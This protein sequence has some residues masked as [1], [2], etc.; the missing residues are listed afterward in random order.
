M[1]RVT[2]TPTTPPSDLPQLLT[3]KQAAAY[4]QQS[5]WTIREA[6]KRGE[7][8]KKC[9]GRKIILIPREHFTQPAAEAVL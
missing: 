7:I 1:S 2:V 6:V 9:F 4:T 8:P 3:I 5:Q